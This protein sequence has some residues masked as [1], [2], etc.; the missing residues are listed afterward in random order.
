[1]Q[2]DIKIN[3]GKLKSKEVQ[4]LL[5]CGKKQKELVRNLEI[6]HANENDGILV[7]DNEVNIYPLDNQEMTIGAEPI[8]QPIIETNEPSIGLTN[9]PILESLKKTTIPTLG[10]K[11][12]KLMKD[13]P[14]L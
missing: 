1:L 12:V 3:N 2:E 4:A 10:F 7:Q 14:N 9:G 13:P 6:N 11:S 5:T 8:M